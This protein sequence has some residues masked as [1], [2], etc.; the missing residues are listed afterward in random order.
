MTHTHVKNF[1]TF[2]DNRIYIQLDTFGRANKISMHLRK[3]DEQW[4]C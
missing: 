4:Y 2:L 1:L 3:Y